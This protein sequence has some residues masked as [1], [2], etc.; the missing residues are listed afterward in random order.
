MGH[1]T[2]THAQRC[3]HTDKD[4]LTRRHPHAQTKRQKCTHADTRSQTDMCKTHTHRHRH[5]KRDKAT[6]IHRQTRRYTCIETYGDA[7][8]QTE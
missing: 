6:H 7:H 4:T 3:T 1:H 2:P 8:R 5:I